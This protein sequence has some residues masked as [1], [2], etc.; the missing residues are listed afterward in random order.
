ME[1]FNMTENKQSKNNLFYPYSFD[2]LK[3]LIKEIG[4]EGEWRKCT[5][6]HYQFTNI[7][8]AHFNFWPSTGRVQI[9]GDKRAVKTFRHK[10]LLR[11]SKKYQKLFHPEPNNIAIA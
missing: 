8:G 5:E 4:G 3:E 9:N 11:V 7:Y 2:K 1:N 6:H 10:Y